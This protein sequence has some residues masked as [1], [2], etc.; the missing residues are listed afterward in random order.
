MIEYTVDAAKRLIRVRMSGG[1]TT[2]DMVRHLSALANDPQFD[3]TFNA[4][5]YITD[6]ARMQTTLFDT[7]LKRIL[8]QWQQRRKGVKWAVVSASHIQLALT[9]LVTDS[10]KFE[11][12]QLRLF[13]DE[14]SALKWLDSGPPG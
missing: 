3:P 13:D 12:V 10:I 6:D 1:N 8:E 9:K 11:L 14:A 7:L 2:T 5:F 4:L